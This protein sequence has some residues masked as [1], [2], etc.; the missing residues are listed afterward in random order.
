MTDVPPPLDLPVRPTLPAPA[1]PTLGS[2][3]AAA[4]L[5]GA[6]DVHVTT[7]GVPFVR[8]EGA[9]IRFDAPPT[10]ADEAAAI[11]AEIRRAANA[12]G[13]DDLDVCVDIP[14][15]GRCR[16]NLHRHAHGPGVSLKLVPEQLLDIPALGLPESL[17]ELTDFRVG[18]VLVTGPT[19]CG[20]SS[21]LAALLDRVNRTR[22]D[23]VITI[24]DPV[25]FVFKSELCNVTQR[26]VGPHSR[27]FAS[28]L[29]A[30]LREDPDVILVSELRD[31]ETIRTAIVAAETGHLVLGTLHT[32][33]AASTLNRL[34][35]VFPPKEQKQIRTMLAGSLR[36]IVSQRLLPRSGGG[37]RVPAYEILRVT[38]AVATLISDARTNQLPS[39]LQ[40]GRRLGM[41][42]F[43]TRLEELVAARLIDRETAARNSKTPK[44]FGGGAA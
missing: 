43:D 36:A 23:H 28:A 2:I 27:S 44:R 14:G 42:D 38:P 30:S 11:H 9:L 18:L 12:P 32:I 34:L 6:S 21:T 5:A 39:A 31:L 29:R 20:K 4:R 3:L 26:Q 16:V 1:E 40:T 33:D 7:G 35:D 25:E 8:I 41:I 17:Y 19:N 13:T 22:R 24:E 37:R 15:A 10:T